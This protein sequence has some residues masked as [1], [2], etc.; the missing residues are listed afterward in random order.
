MKDTPDF[1]PNR[2]DNVT[3]TNG[4]GAVPNTTNRA[5]GPFVVAG[6]YNANNI[7]I[8]PYST[9][10]RRYRVNSLYANADLGY[11]DFLFLNLDA[12]GISASGAADANRFILLRSLILPIV[13]PAGRS[14]SVRRWRDR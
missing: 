14:M 9:A 5:V 7:L 6:N 13:A 1:L 3:T 11:K 2:Q 10:D 4:I 12:L 8:K